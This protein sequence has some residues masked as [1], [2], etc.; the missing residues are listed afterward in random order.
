MSI[1]NLF[2]NLVDVA[3][4][5]FL[6]NFIFLRVCL[7]SF[8]VWAV[9]LI[10]NGKVFR[11]KSHPPRSCSFEVPTIWLSFEFHS[12]FVVYDGWIACNYWMS[13]TRTNWIIHRMTYFSRFFFFFSNVFS[14]SFPLLSSRRCLSRFPFLASLTSINFLIKENVYVFIFHRRSVKTKKMKMNIFFLFTRKKNHLQSRHI[15]HS[16]KFRLLQSLCEFSSD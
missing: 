2:S 5:F 9:A 7:L 13:G 12:Y 1:Q 11:R 3:S 16:L 6:T 10:L 8:R 4:P 14:T 15:T